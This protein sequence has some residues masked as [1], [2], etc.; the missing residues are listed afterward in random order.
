MRYRALRV[1]WAAVASAAVSLAAAVDPA[2]A[3][4]IYQGGAPDQNGVILSQSPNA[5]AMSFTLGSDS[6]I[7][8]A[9]WWGGCFDPQA[10]SANACD[11]SP[12]FTITFWSNSSSGTPDTVLDFIPILVANQ[13][14]TGNTIGPAPPPPPPPWNEYSYSASFAGLGLS[15]NTT[16]WLEIQNT[17]G[18][19]NG[20][21]GW[22]TT[23]SAPGAA[24]LEWFN[25]NNSCPTPVIDDTNWCALP[26]QLA[27]NLVGT[28]GLPSEVPEPNSLLI[29]GA[30]LLGLL[31]FRRR[32]S[33]AY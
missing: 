16:Y 30:G 26:Q 29:L 17:S 25:A 8:G 31:A 5:V 3:D 7:T 14:A 33:L 20:T 24:Q 1:L 4:L 23:S 9:N 2:S 10:T 21:W 13:T 6:T 27:F 12:N 19:T 18:E 32:C 28:T 15:A 22:E 11:A